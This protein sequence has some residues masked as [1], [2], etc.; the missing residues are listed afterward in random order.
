MTT[1]TVDEMKELKDIMVLIVVIQ[2]SCRVFEMCAVI[3][4]RCQGKSLSEL[5]D[6]QRNL[7]PRLR[8]IS[9]KVNDADFKA[10][11]KRANFEADAEIDSTITDN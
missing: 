1:A 6:W 8:E 5:G 3:P 11:S 9:A 2:H 4:R 10:I 7:T